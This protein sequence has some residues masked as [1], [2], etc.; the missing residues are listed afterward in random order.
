[1]SNALRICAQPFL[2][3]CTTCGLIVV[4]IEFG[5]HGFRMRRDLR[6]RERSG[7]HLDEDQIIARGPVLPPCVSGVIRFVVG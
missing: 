1:M 7:K 3:I 2:R 5:L 6:E 4:G